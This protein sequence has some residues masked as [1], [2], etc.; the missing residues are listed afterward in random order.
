MRLSALTSTFLSAMTAAVLFTGCATTGTGHAPGTWESVQPMLEK[1]CVHCHGTERLSG[2]PA[3]T[4]S[5]VLAEFAKS[6][7]WIV[8]GS[9]EGSRIYQ[10][11][12]L[13]DDQPGAMPPSG[14]AVP[15]A[16]REVL[17]AWIANRA[18]VPP[19]SVP[20]VPREEAPRSR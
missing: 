18:P 11:V 2:M 9:P 7:R 15:K 4:S 8:P 12:I 14:H 17:R 6:N 19:V 5:A 3:M 1:H 10:V 20:L 13:N 16:D